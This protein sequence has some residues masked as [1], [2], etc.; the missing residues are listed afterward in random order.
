MTSLLLAIGDIGYYN[1]LLL[2]YKLH[3]TCNRK[4]RQV[5]LIQNAA[6]KMNLWAVKAK[7][8][9]RRE[10]IKIDESYLI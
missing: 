8:D 3:F 1:N 10:K 7:L 4:V 5:D 2:Q 9:S 6:S